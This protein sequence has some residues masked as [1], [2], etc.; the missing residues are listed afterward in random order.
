MGRLTTV[1]PRVQMAQG[2]QMQTAD[3]ESWR[4]GKTTAERGYGGK[5]Q[6]ER[7]R[8]LFKHPL[9]CYCQAK[10]IVTAATVVDHKVPHRGDQS[11]FWDQKNWQPL[12]KTCHDSDKQAEERGDR[13]PRW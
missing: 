12:C 8:F 13:E 7:E 1:K 5:W 11:L 3:C 9:C 10:G 4:S 2:R 6:R